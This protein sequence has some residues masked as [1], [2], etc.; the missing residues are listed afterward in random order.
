[1]LAPPVNAMHELNAAL[2]LQKRRSS[3]G[4]AAEQLDA[5][6]IDT[7]F[8]P[9]A[10]SIKELARLAAKQAQASRER[11]RRLT[12][13]RT[14]AQLVAPRDDGLPLCW[15]EQPDVQRVAVNSSSKEFE[16]VSSHLQAT[17]NTAARV[18]SV[19]RIQNAA[20]YRSTMRDGSETIMFHG[21]RSQGNEDSIVQV[22]FR[23][24]PARGCWFAYV[25][26]Y[27]NGGYA[28]DDADGWRH[29]FVCIVSRHGQMMDDATMRV[30]AQG[31]AYPQWIV[32]YRVQ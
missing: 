12:N 15:A 28:F 14:P 30:V 22:G 6:S 29:I 7:A 21:C 23:C 8:G 9:P 18:G 25:S 2:A 24:T 31:G 13:A 4:S 19:I 32:H 11:E 3:V 5:L 27:S 17:L 10:E 1:M 26:N 16:L 20:V